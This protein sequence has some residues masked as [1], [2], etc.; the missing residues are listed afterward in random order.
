MIRRRFLSFERL[1]LIFEISGDDAGNKE[2]GPQN[3][4]KEKQL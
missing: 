1:V 3:R 2:E 4:G